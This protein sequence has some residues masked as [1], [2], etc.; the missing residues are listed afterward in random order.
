V[1]EVFVLEKFIGKPEQQSQHPNMHPEVFVLEKS[2]GKPEQQS[3]HPNV[4]MHCTVLNLEHICQEATSGIPEADI[5]FQNK[6][7][8][9]TLLYFRENI[10]QQ[11]FFKYCTMS[12]VILFMP[13]QSHKIFCS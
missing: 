11:H 2:I 5:R 7:K 10:L 6:I 13:I 9:S 3:Q 12:I 1:K 8:Q 4:Y